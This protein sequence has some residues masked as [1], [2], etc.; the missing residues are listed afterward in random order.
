M[1]VPMFAPMLVGG[2]SV[3]LALQ[4]PVQVVLLRRESC[5]NILKINTL[6]KKWPRNPTGVH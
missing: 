5:L 4:Q 2:H 6:K 1:L 3:G